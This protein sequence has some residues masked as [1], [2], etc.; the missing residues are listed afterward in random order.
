[1]LIKFVDGDFRTNGVLLEAGK[2]E[3]EPQGTIIELNCRACDGNFRVTAGVMSTW[4]G[5]SLRFRHS[6]KIWGGVEKDG[7]HN[8]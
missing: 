7:I 4:R 3:G 6:L 5:Y 2:G 8:A 1:M